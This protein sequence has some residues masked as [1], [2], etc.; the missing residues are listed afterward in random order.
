MESAFRHDGGR[1]GLAGARRSQIHEGLPHR[2]ATERDPLVADSPGRECYDMS[3]SHNSTPLIDHRQAATDTRQPSMHA[4]TGAY[5]C[6][7]IPALLIQAPLVRRLSS[8]CQQTRD[9][10]RS[11]GWVVFMMIPAIILFWVAVEGRVAALQMS[12]SHPTAPASATLK[13]FH[14]GLNASL[15]SDVLTHLSDSLGSPLGKARRNTKQR[16]S[17]PPTVMRLATSISCAGTLPVCSGSEV[18]RLCSGFTSPCPASRER[19]HK[20][21]NPS[22]IAWRNISDHGY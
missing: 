20:K 18:H 13:R 19:S 22:P 21:Y 6:W 14:A 7:S 12:K 2:G 15:N 10:V 1:R 4:G 11:S 8:T 17:A 16:K 3:R 5:V 9:Q